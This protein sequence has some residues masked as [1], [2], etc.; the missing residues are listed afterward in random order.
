M[1]TLPDLLLHNQD[2]VMSFINKA[3]R[4]ET[5]AEIVQLIRIRVIDQ[6][7]NWVK[8]TA[9]ESI[10]KGGLHNTCYRLEAHAPNNKEEMQKVFLVVFNLRPLMPLDVVVVFRRTLEENAETYGGNWQLLLLT[11]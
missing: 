2:E 4:C 8:D 7:L 5:G 9:A 3:V 6:H 11:R 1:T 10:I